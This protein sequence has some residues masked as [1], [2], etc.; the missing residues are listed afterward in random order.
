MAA[1]IVGRL[2][3]TMASPSAMCLA[4]YARSDPIRDPA[5]REPR[6]DVSSSS[7]TA[8]TLALSSGRRDSFSSRI[9]VDAVLLPSKLGAMASSSELESALVGESRVGCCLGAGFVRSPKRAALD[10]PL[11]TRFGVLGPRLSCRRLSAMAISVSRVDDANLGIVLSCEETTSRKCCHSAKKQ[12]L[13][14][15]LADGMLFMSAGVGI[16][17]GAPTNSLYVLSGMQP[18]M[19]ELL[20]YAGCQHL[21]EYI[22]EKKIEKTMVNGKL[23]IPNFQAKK[24]KQ[25]RLVWKLLVPGAWVGHHQ[26]NQLDSPSPPND[27]I[28]GHR[29]YLLH[30]LQ[31]MYDGA[32]PQL[33]LPNLV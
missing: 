8:M 5:M 4:R 27:H 19:S 13:G 31:H 23:G 28:L 10:E 21:L 26:N 16:F 17:F 1:G 3:G 20:Y 6:I 2:S 11:T 24:K 18:I 22:L 25:F 29:K 12:V 7:A 33:E 30:M 9:L 14:D 32:R 15:W